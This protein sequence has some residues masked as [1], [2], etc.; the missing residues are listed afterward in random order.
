M[1]EPTALSQSLTING[2][3]YVKR[4]ELVS[5]QSERDEWRAA[6]LK[7]VEILKRTVAG[8][9]DV[10]ERLAAHVATK[11]MQDAITTAPAMM[12]GDADDTPR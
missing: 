8:M 1:P 4:S 10:N 3:V 12:P 9:Q 5:V 2:V 11:Q 6:A 7:G